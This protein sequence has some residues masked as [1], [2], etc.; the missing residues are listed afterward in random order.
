MK[1]KCHWKTF[2]KTQSNDLKTKKNQKIEK[3]YVFLPYSK[4][5]IDF[6]NNDF[7][8]KMVFFIRTF[9]IIPLSEIFIK[10]SVNGLQ[11]LIAFLK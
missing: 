7:S 4:T 5:H 1:I 9:R 3:I 8:A 6:I 2:G 11:A 10:K